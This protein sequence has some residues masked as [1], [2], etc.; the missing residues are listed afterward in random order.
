MMNPLSI[1]EMDC[2]LSC[3]KK[4]HLSC[5]KAIGSGVKLLIRGNVSMNNVDV[6]GN[7]QMVMEFET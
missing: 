1:T 7:Y 4:I 3:W 2:W 5:M 6:D